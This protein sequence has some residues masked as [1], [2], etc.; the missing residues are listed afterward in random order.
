MPGTETLPVTRTHARVGEVGPS[1][2]SGRWLAVTTVTAGCDGE[3][4][5]GDNGMGKYFRWHNKGKGWI[6]KARFDSDWQRQ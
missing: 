3:I 4:G 1:K 2:G 5:G 6:G